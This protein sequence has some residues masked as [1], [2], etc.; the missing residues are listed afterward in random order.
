MRKTQTCPK[1]GGKNVGD[2]NHGIKRLT[3]HRYVCFTCGYVEYHI[4]EADILS[5]VEKQYHR[6]I[7][8]DKK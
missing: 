8:K 2:I 7:G 6:L 3:M 5:R 1:C 4:V